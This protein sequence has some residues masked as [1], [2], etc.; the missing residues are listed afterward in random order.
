MTSIELLNLLRTEAELPALLDV[1][2]RDPGMTYQ[3]LQWANAPAN[4]LGTQVTSLQQAF[5]VLGRNQLYRALTVSMFRLGASTHQD[6]MNR[7]WKWH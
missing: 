3:L 4:G 1:V 5:L 7:C 2:K 6:A